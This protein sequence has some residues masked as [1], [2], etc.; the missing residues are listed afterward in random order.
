MPRVSH[1]EIPT[2]DPKRSLTFYRVM[3]FL[4]R[5]GF[6]ILG[7]LLSLGSLLWLSEQPAISGQAASTSAVVDGTAAFARLKT[8]AGEWRGTVMT[9]TGPAATVR[10]E[11]RS[12]GSVVQETLFPGTEQEMISVYH[13]DGSQLVMT[14]YCS[15][16][17][18]PRMKLDTARSKPAILVFDFTGGTNMDPAKDMH[19][20]S[21]EIRI[22]S[23]DRIESEWAAYQSGKQAGTNKFFLTRVKRALASR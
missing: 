7:M 6:V 1:F 9:P 16:G 12:N 17:N 5:R 2:A 10:Y 15:A 20:H 21:G 3:T 22:L 14:H 13:M 8:L 4:K 18:Q 19:V 11:V 23:D